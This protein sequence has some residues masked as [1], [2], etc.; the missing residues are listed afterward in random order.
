MQDILLILKPFYSNLL[1]NYWTCHYIPIINRL[2]TFLTKKNSSIQIMVILVGT[3]H[4]VPQDLR[5]ANE[6]FLM[7]SLSFCWC[8]RNC[9]QHLQRCFHTINYTA[10]LMLLHIYIE[11]LYMKC[12]SLRLWV[13]LSIRLVII[14]IIKYVVTMQFKMWG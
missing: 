14:I 8:A 9:T 12:I 2:H 7:C 1:H 11:V 13:L 6:A 5:H 3:I 10:T 4:G